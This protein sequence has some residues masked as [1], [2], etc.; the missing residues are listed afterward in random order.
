MYDGGD[1]M[2]EQRILK[3]E[4]NSNDIVNISNTTLKNTFSN[5]LKG[6][7]L[8]PVFLFSFL[9]SSEQNKISMEDILNQKKILKAVKPYM[10]ERSQDTMSRIESMIDVV[11]ALN[12]YATGQYSLDTSYQKL[13]NS[14][15]NKPIKILEA[16][17]PHM[18]GQRKEFIDKVL[19]VNDRIDQ[20]K[21]RSKE[22]RNL[23]EDFEDI[24]DILEVF[25]NTK[26]VEMRKVLNKAKT[27]I[28][29]I[30]Q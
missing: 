13:Q 26:V 11:D 10:E 27:M 23:L 29:I 17:R 4:E 16:I 22:K 12:R 20:L 6:D 1:G 25:E 18:K 30:K 5:L 14:I 8:L 7:I 24:V 2:E 21:Q 3:K 28:K 9:R 15:E 19:M